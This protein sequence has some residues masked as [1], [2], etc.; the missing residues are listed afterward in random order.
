AMLSD[1]EWNILQCILQ[2]HSYA[3]T[4]EILHTSA[5]SV[6]NAMQRIRRKMRTVQD[7]TD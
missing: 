4:A 6:D 2:G 3:E 5:K 1:K 7:D